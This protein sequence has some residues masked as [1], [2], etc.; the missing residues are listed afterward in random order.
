MN[1][2]PRR[3]CVLVNPKSGL[4]TSFS[5]LRRAFDG[6]WEVAGVDLVY[7]FCQSVQDGADKAARAVAEGADTVI[8]VGGD[9]T[10]S[11]IGRALVGTGAALGIVP[12]GSGNGL[13]RHFGIPLSAM[14][15]VQ[16]IARAEARPIDVGMV[17]GRPFLVTCSMAWDASIA[18]AFAKMPFRGILP[19][20]MAGV[21]E[22]LG[23]VA[24]P[25]EVTLDDGK[26]LRFEDPIVFTIANL[27]QYGGGAI[28]APDAKADDG[29]L[30]LVVGLR[31]DAPKL[32]INIG[33]LFDGTMN[34][35]PE[36]V[37]RRFASLVV[38]RARATPVQVDGELVEVPREIE[39]TVRPRALNVLVP[40]GS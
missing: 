3:V 14:R 20:V 34:R 29:R 22:F 25:M 19:Y 23:Y 33:R 8:A 18:Q 2:G 13:A 21:Q 4:G 7:R 28:I 39:I 27:S 16:A 5:S 10:V 32:L 30:E 35:L 38:R 15:A 11:T 17:N 40:P 1:G 37:S 31:K 36:V 12:T 6:Y 26:T 24:E 9:G